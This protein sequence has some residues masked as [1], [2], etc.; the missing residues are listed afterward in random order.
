MIAKTEQLK[1]ELESQLSKVDKKNAGTN[2]E[3]K[4]LTGN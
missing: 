1:E 3:R 2:S 4:D